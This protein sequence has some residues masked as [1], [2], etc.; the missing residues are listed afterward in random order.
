MIMP[1]EKHLHQSRIAL[2]R[3]VMTLYSFFGSRPSMFT[4]MERAV[5]AMI[6]I[7]AS[8]IVRIEV[9]H[10]DLS[11]LAQLICSEARRPCWI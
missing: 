4:P 7:A 1:R 6:S 2:R 5:P 10:L 9:G 11:D 3:R 8:M